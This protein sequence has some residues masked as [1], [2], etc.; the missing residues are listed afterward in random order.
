MSDKVGRV[1]EVVMARPD[2]RDY[3]SERGRTMKVSKWKPAPILIRYPA[4]T[5]HDRVIS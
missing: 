3:T 1:V 4:R 2:H 5:S